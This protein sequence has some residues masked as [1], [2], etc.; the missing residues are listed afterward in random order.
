VLVFERPGEDAEEGGVFGV[1]VG[2]F[3]EVFAKAARMRPFWSSMTA[4]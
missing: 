2:A 1:V 4:P 3:A